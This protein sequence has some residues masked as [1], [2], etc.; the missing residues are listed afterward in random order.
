MQL[1]S[2]V[3]R[4]SRSFRFSSKICLH[5]KWGLSCKW[6]CGD[7]LGVSP[8]RTQLHSF[9]HQPPPRSPACEPTHLVQCLRFSCLSNTSH[10]CMFLSPLYSL[11]GCRC[12]LLPLSSGRRR[13]QQTMLHATTRFAAT[14]ESLLHQQSARR[15]CKRR[16]DV[17]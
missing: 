11:V 7:L 14:S 10:W 8:G 15:S 13:Q 16:S 2:A 6:G 3:V 4:S 12:C 9:H 1:E 17:N 5:L